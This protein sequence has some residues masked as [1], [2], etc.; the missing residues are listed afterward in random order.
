M[1]NRRAV[2]PHSYSWL[3]MFPVLFIIVWAIAS[4]TW[5]FGWDQGIYAWMGDVINQGGLPYRDAWDLKGPLSPYIFAGTQLLFGHSMWAIRLFDLLMLLVA[6]GMLAILVS[7]LTNKTVALWATF[8]FVLWFASGNFWNTAQPDGWVSMIVLIGMTPL[9]IARDSIRWYLALFAGMCIGCA[10]L[11]KPLFILYLLL[12]LMAI[13]LQDWPR[14][15]RIFMNWILVLVGSAFLLVISAGW[16][17]YHGALSDLIEGSIIYPLKIYSGINRL[18]I[19]S[20]IQRITTYAISGGGIAL[21]FPII[22]LGV[23]MLWRISKKKAVVVVFWILISFFIVIVQ[24]RYYAYQWVIIYPP[25][26]LLC[27]VGFHTIF[28]LNQSTVSEPKAQH[29]QPVQLLGIFM[30]V[31][32]IFYATIHPLFEVSKWISYISNRNSR[33]Q[34]YDSFGIPGSDIQ[35]ANYIQERTTEGDKIFIWGWNASIYFLSSRQSSSRFGYSLP[36]LM[37]E[38]TEVREAYRLELLGDLSSNP[39][40]YIVVAPLADD[41]VGKKY[42][43]SDFTGFADFLSTRYVEEKVF[44]DLIIYHLKRNSSVNT[45]GRIFG[46]RTLV[47]RMNSINSLH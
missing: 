26:V 42:F 15:S 14:K 44:G 30:L 39:P 47:F 20:L 22:G 45:G 9:L 13:S 29:R 17:A 16:F 12:V 43:L 18:S 31:V 36:L 28:F 38:G 7:N 21:I 24:N 35:A 40:V 19:G 11:I 4:L 2:L 27:A 23:L 41:I 3:Y 46:L 6:S 10:I 5:P 32:I 1:K 34:Y 25:I 8:L 33:E 37:G